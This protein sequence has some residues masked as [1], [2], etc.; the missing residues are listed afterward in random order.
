[1]MGVP[2]QQQQQLL[3]TLCSCVAFLDL[4]DNGSQRLR[5]C[6]YHLSLQG[7]GSLSTAWPCHHKQQ[8]SSL[9]GR[10]CQDAV[11]GVLVQEPAE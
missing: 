10:L 4:L 6:T 1:M 2:Q 9:L 3:G 7:S 11:G 8:L 5:V